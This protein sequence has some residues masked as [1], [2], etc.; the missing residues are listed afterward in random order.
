MKIVYNIGLILFVPIFYVCYLITALIKTF[1]QLLQVPFDT[2][3]FAN[4]YTA[5]FYNTKAVL[6]GIHHNCKDH[7]TE[8]NDNQEKESEPEKEKIGFKVFP[9]AAPGLPGYSTIDEEEE[10]YDE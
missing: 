1:I 5:F 9:S 4:A 8:H 7:C 10:E 2:Q 3:R 6:D